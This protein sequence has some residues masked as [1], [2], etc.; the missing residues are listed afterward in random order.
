MARK[1]RGG[2]KKSSSKSKPAI[3]SLSKGKSK[4]PAKTRVAKKT[5]RGG[6]VAR[7]SSSQSRVK[8]RRY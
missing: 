8:G 7:K 2:S 3:L 4:R 5:T 6:K 1:K